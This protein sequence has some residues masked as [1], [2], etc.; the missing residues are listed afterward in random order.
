MLFQ[1][2]NPMEDIIV[3]T[4][5]FSF[6]HQEMQPL[7]QSRQIVDEDW[8]FLQ[9]L[10]NRQTHKHI[11]KKVSRHT[12]NKFYLSFQLCSLFWPQLVLFYFHFV[13]SSVFYIKRYSTDDDAWLYTAHE[14][15]KEKRSQQ[16]L[17]INLCKKSGLSVTADVLYECV[18]IDESSCVEEIRQQ[19]RS[20]WGKEHREC[21]L[22]RLPHHRSP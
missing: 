21:I 18:K 8:R 22:H 2:L 12:H 1:E 5:G 19:R 13:I 10:T 17:I 4:S 11:N 7:K 15:V 9:P 6:H 20:S 14:A 16:R 3:L